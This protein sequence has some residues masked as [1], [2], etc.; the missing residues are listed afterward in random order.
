MLD[1][2]DNLTGAAIREINAPFPEVR[3]EVPLRTEQEYAATVDKLV[4][5]LLSVISSPYLSYVKLGHSF[6]C[7]LDLVDTKKRREAERTM[8]RITQRSGRKVS[9]DWCF[10]YDPS[11]VNPKTLCYLDGNKE[12]GTSRSCQVR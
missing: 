11:S 7:M 3:C 10:L 12:S 9:F 4:L 8:F 6:P 1:H 2:C 5:K